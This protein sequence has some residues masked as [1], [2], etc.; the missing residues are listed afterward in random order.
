VEVTDLGS[1]NG[2]FVNS[3]RIPAHRPVLLRQ[4]DRLSLGTE[5]I[6]Y[7]ME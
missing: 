2:T 5:A 7:R 1:T 3:R 4:S 6:S